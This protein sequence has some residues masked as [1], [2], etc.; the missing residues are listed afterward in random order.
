M[1]PP[2]VHD[3]PVRD[4]CDVHVHGSARAERVCPDVFWGEFESGRA[5]SLALRPEDSDDD[6]VAD[7]SKTLRGRVVADCGGQITVMLL[8]AE[9]YVDA[10]LNWSDSRALQFEV[11]YNLTSDEI[12]L[13]LQGKYDLGDMLKPPDWGIRAEEGVSGDED[14]VDEGK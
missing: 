11:R 5:H 13:V 9:E 7:R 10:C 8:M 4:V 1:L 6:G 3:G 14:K 12:L 2:D